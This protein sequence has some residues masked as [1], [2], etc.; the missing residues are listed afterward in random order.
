MG[1]VACVLA[2][3][4]LLATLVTPVSAQEEPDQVLSPGSSVSIE[5]DDGSVTVAATTSAAAVELM[6][7][8]IDVPAGDQADDGGVSLSAVGTST[9]VVEAVDA[10]SGVVVLEFPHQ[11][12]VEP[13]TGDV[14]ARVSEL[15]AGVE[16]VLPVDAALA[17]AVDQ[18]T[19]AVYSRDSS[20]EP[21]VRLPS[22]YDAELGR[23]RAVSDHLSEFAVMAAVDQAVGDGPTI[24]LDPDDDLGFAN[25][26]G[27]RVSE[28]DKNLQ[29]VDAVAAELTAVCDANVVITRGDEPFVDKE[30]RG[31]V[32]ANAGP[33]LTVTL[34]FNALNGEPWGVDDDGGVRVWVSDA[35][36]VAFAQ[37]FLDAVPEFTGRPATEGVNGPE[38]D[39]PYAP[40][41]AVPGPYAHVE[42]LYLDHNF[43]YPVIDE[44]FD[45]VVDAVVAALTEQLAAQG[46]DCDRDGGLPDPPSEE[47][48]IELRNLGYQ[49]YQVY[50]ADPVSFATGNFITDEPIFTLSGVGDQLIDLTLT[51]NS[52][53]SRPGTFGTGWSFAYNSAIQL[54]TSGA[55]AVRLGDG[56]TRYFVD[57]GDTWEEQS[58][59]D[60]ELVR[61]S[62]TEFELTFNHFTTVG[63]ELQTQGYG[64]MTSI[65][66]RQ[67]NEMTFEWGDSV[68]GVYPL[69]SVTDEAGQT[70][71]LTANDDAQ[72]S[73]IE[74]PDGRVW[75][76]G[77]DD[78]RLASITDA[79][80]VT[81]R[82]TY[83]EEGWLDS[84]VDGAGATFVT[85]DYDDEGR[86]VTQ[87]NATGDER[88]VAYDD[89]TTVYTDAL[90]NET[91]YVRNDLGQV[92][93]TIDALGGE[94]TTEFDDDFNPVAQVDAAGGEWVT[95]YDDDGRPTR[96][97]DPLGNETTF[98]YNEFGDLIKL[99]EPDGLGGVRTTEY[100]VND[101][102]RIVKTTFD[103]GTS[104]QSTFD[105]HGDQLTYTDANGN[106][107]EYRFDA[108]G[109]VTATID[110]LDGVAEATYTLSNQMATLTDPKGNTVEYFYD[111]ADNQTKIVDAVGAEWTYTYGPGNEMLT[112][113]DPL[114]RVIT[115]TYD[116]NLNLTRIDFPDGTSESFT[117]DGEYNVTVTVDRRGN[118]TTTN[119]DELL[120]P[121]LV[122]DQIGAEWTTRYD[123]LGNPTQ[124][125]D[126]EGNT[127]GLTYDAL[128]RVV[129][130]TDPL[131]N[132]WESAYD[133]AGNLTTE[134]APDGSELR[135]VY[136]A[137]GR[138]EA[139][140]DEEGNRFSFDY[141][142]AGNPIQQTDRRGNVTT[143]N[144]D[145]MNRVDEVVNPDG[146]V[147]TTTYD[148]AG[149]V[150]ATTDPI[151]GTVTAVYDARNRAVT[152]ID[153][154]GFESTNE[155]D[156]AGNPRFHIDAE[157]HRWE[158]RYDDMNRVIARVSPLGDT[159]GYTYDG[160]GNVTARIMPD[161][162]VNRLV[163]NERNELV[164]II[165]NHR[166]GQPDSADVN[167]RTR[168]ELSP[169][170]N[171]TAIVNPNGER[172]EF[173]YDGLRRLKTK[174]DPL[175]RVEESFYNPIGDLVAEVDGKGNRTEHTYFSDGQLKTTTYADG[176]AVSYTYDGD[177]FPSTMTD[178]IG[179]TTWKRDWRGNVTNTSDANGNELSYDYDL[180]GNVTALTYPD[181][182]TSNRTYDLASRP[183]T[184]TDRTGEISYD[185]DRLGRP[186]RVTHPNGMATVF[187]Y[188]PEGKVTEIDH[189]SPHGSAGR[190]GADGLGS[191]VRFEYGYTVDDLVAD[192]TIAFKKNKGESATYS[193]DGVDRLIGSETRAQG[194][195]GYEVEYRYDAAGNRTWM[196]STDDPTTNSPTDGFEVDYTY[197]AADQLI[198]E[199]RAYKNRSTQVRRSYDGNGNLVSQVE[200]RLNKK[201]RPVG[202]PAAESFAYNLEDELV[203]D[204]TS[205]WER[206]GMGRMLAWTNGRQTAE[207]VYDDLWLIAQQGDI[208]E[209]YIRDHDQALL[210]QS[211]EPNK[212]EVLLYD[213]LGTI[214]GVADKNGNTP[215]LARFSDFGV[216]I[217]QPP[218]RSVFG[219]VGEVQDP[220]GDRVHFYA[221]AY[222]PAT[223]RFIQQDR[224]EG[225][226]TVP[227]SLHNYTYAYSNPTTYADFLG[228]W[229]CCGVD[230][231]IPNPVDAVKSVAG[232]VADGVQAAG[233]LAW[234]YR[235]EILDVAGMVP[236]IGEVADV[237][238]GL[239]YLAEG[240]YTNAA[241]SLA[242]AVPVVG[243]AVTGL[244][245][246][247][248]GA[249][250]VSDLTRYS[251]KYGDE[252][253]ASSDELVDITTSVRR[254]EN[255]SSAGTTAT[256]QVEEVSAVPRKADADP[257]DNIAPSSTPASGPAAVPT[258]TKPNP[259]LSTNSTPSGQTSM[260]PST[261][262]VTRYDPDFAVGQL[263]RNGD[264]R[265]S[266]LVDFGTS[267]G[268]TRTQTATGPIKF[269][270]S[271]GVIRLT[272][273][274]GSGRAPG[275]NF[276]HVEL[277][278]AVGQRIDAF[279][280][281][282]TRKDIL[283]HT[284]II[285]DLGS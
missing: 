96:R 113:T 210:S 95:E 168:Y 5:L 119:Y 220:S 13:A 191:S 24:V 260:A 280:E 143:T 57:N 31:Q 239:L 236:V 153:Q 278:N 141:D 48:L 271:N 111:L 209:I 164:E 15:R 3:A 70:V 23:V 201:G 42:V 265:A 55:A 93:K 248:K 132:E 181:G 227:A 60:A 68:G 77:Y 166:P 30:I 228:Y 116:D 102:G 224:M 142:A 186:T 202:K 231:S 74:H 262:A 80:G 253:L 159:E 213:L 26:P 244:K 197:D 16:L 281:L 128:S 64:L 40:L 17:A 285:W 129:L 107:T 270:D 172:T 268:W 97:I 105:E 34:A 238:N 82:F 189:R 20:D 21:W 8:E 138:M 61:L 174:T 53:D 63:F 282:V 221:R 284:P 155:Y 59:D 90:G 76:L 7:D 187:A 106:T 99:E 219:F 39:L 83:T 88:T 184:I 1:R 73:Q 85:N 245:T 38:G 140:V 206:D 193:Y 250:A 101:R 41:D 19:V 190:G 114:G 216:R 4:I 147:A 69:E 100:E 222:D 169:S 146:G 233:E 273:K 157:G 109:N 94:S 51:Y 175:G 89:D 81:R 22:A 86:V 9:V 252:I 126:P 14:P 121:E 32:A 258:G 29:L 65:V 52:Q 247:Y 241:L 78:D 66:D 118:E 46:D 215:Q 136:D 232:K 178:T 135:Y 163:Y 47:E 43:D 165:E 246:T 134:T 263:V 137:M 207:Q 205:R 243:Q 255:T 276:P 196:S 45:L 54:D 130:R 259:K 75:V 198:A 12:E 150:K 37:R 204:G 225:D 58:G 67:G 151:G 79:R 264:A 203:A 10:L 160:N 133:T 179:H 283:N 149:N 218:H 256:R 35:D 108:R 110:A 36:D 200:Q 194:Q 92:T 120:R 237:A 44:Q 199:R 279:G 115:Y 148:A 182:F 62:D 180:A 56:G 112:E 144:Y 131:G 11:V 212:T 192:R 229:G 230:V 234:E 177:N 249:N 195:R 117:L 211:V 123:P 226:A 98:I 242:A 71:R 185:R 217:G 122:T 254:A 152:S 84:I 208:N 176:T 72:I 50:G 104:E 167:V 274:S 269:E 261:S 125:V 162:R 257:I 6:L 158:L 2:G 28:L 103:D 25:W 275:S 161:G 156:L 127:I 267:Q 183:A 33:D 251:T 272:I 27:G 223:G 266:D 235:H 87:A 139:S 154:F 171:V 145:A 240:D 173:T 214:H 277:R 18:N 91:T 49:N 188:D 124:M 170:G